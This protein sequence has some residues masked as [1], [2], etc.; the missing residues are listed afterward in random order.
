[1]ATGTGL[2]IEQLSAVSYTALLTLWSRALEA[3]SADPILLDPAAI[4][5]TEQLRPHVAAMQTPFHQQLARDELP[6]LLVTLMALRAQ[7]FDQK[8]RDFLMRFPRGVIVNLG[9]GLDTRFER[10]DADSERVIDSVR[11]I[12]I[13]L[14]PVIALKR[15]ML[16]PHPRH[17]FVAGSVLD[18]GWMDVLERYSDRRFLFLAE[19]LLMYF[20]PD[21]VKRLV[22]T[23]ATRFSGSELVADVFHGMWLRPPWRALTVRKMEQRLHVGRD[24]S[25]QFGLDAPAEMAQWHPA[26]RYLSMWS[27]FDA[28]ERKLGW[29]QIF[30]LVPLIRMIQYVVH[31]Q[32]G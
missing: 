14:P 15:E 17:E 20:P 8:A 18:F 32:L 11:V 28:P 5:L 16:A 24:V 12:D 9:A 27:L 31:Y 3:A 25:F 13:D 30:R 7:H 29:M 26:I 6:K 1:M 21:E 10:L 22:V 4:T 19:G 23:L 2:A